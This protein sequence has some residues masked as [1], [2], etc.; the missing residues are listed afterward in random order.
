MDC[1]GSLRMSFQVSVRIRARGVIYQLFENMRRWTSLI[2][3][4]SVKSGFYIIH[5]N[6]AVYIYAWAS[7]FRYTKCYQDRSIMLWVHLILVVAIIVRVRIHLILVMVVYIV[8]II[9][10]VC[11]LGHFLES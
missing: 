1:V 6:Q 10:S 7:F 8:C 2:Y 4:Y 3:I 9:C 11:L 5:Q